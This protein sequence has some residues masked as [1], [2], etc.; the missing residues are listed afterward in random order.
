MGAIVVGELVKR[1]RTQRGLTQVE[2]GR[3]TGLS[4]NYISK[5]EQGQVELPQRG[6]L[7]ALGGALE[8]PV[9]DFYRAAGVLDDLNRNDPPP[10]QLALLSLTGEEEYDADALVAYV[11]SRPGRIFQADLAEARRERTYDEYVEFCLSIFRAWESNSNLGIKALALGR[12]TGT[13]GL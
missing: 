9:E 13:G 8:L 10:R 6:T 12:S 11:E 5:L 3:R 7:D 2:L 1:R 4:Q